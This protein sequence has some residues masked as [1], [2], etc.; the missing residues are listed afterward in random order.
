LLAFTSFIAVTAARA[1]VLFLSPTAVAPTIQHSFSQPPSAADGQAFTFPSPA[2]ALRS[3]NTIQITVNAPAGYAWF[4]HTDP[5]FF[6][7]EL[8]F[9][10]AYGSFF[11]APFAAITLTNFSFNFVQGGPGNLSPADDLDLFPL[12]GDRF[13]V[14]K[15]FSLNGDV[16]FTGFSMTVGYASPYLSTSPLVSFHSAALSFSCIPGSGTDPGQRL[17]LSAVPE[18]TSLAL[19]I[20]GLAVWQFWCY[21]NRRRFKPGG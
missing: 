7:Q 16:A 19:S 1:Q 9:G 18:P 20:C 2:I 8:D 11:N 10:L 4:V 21:A 5:S 12:S 15:A 14:Y 13:Y 6:R 3:Y 17:T